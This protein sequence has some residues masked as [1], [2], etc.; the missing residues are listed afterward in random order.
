MKRVAVVGRS[1]SGKSTFA[2]KLASATGLP[3]IHLDK[4]FW[5]PGWVAEDRNVFAAKLQPYLDQDS[6]ITDGNYT[7]AL[8]ERFAQ[9]DT[10][11][12]FDFHLWRCIAG[13]LQ[14][15]ICF[16]GLT[17]DDM[18]EGCAERINPGF[19]HYVTFIQRPHLIKALER[20]E[21]NCKVIIFK[22]SSEADKW[23]KNNVQN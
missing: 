20:L 11:F 1:G 18:A 10:I 13:I 8:Q 9:V 4:L 6:W 14:R 23:L 16:H 2:K 15:R 3:V 12:F 21:K 17:R 19:L 5:K 7:Q 22:T